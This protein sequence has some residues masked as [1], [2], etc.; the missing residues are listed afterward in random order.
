MGPSS[1][2][3]VAVVVAVI[4]ISSCSSARQSDTSV[5]P[6]PVD[7]VG[8]NPSNGTQATFGVPAVVG[9][10][11]ITASDPV[12]E[13]DDIGPWLTLTVRA[14]NQTEADVQAPQLELHCSGNPA[15]GA[16][17]ETSTF[18]QDEPVSSR[19]FNEGKL[20]LLMPGDGRLGEPRPSCA[21]PA[22]V[23][24]NSLSFDNAGASPPVRV[25][26]EWA[27]PEELIRLLNAAPQP[28]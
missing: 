28:T 1:R 6:Q 13:S 17:L 12:I 5:A 3:S 27:V 11:N 23:I 4:A 20:S 19:S 21:T 7:S 14:E 10:L 26:V 8:T 22:T 25:R 24:A 15:G 18:K 16:W 2:R 9:D